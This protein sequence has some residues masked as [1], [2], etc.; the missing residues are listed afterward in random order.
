MQQL[1]GADTETH[2][3]TLGRAQETLMKGQ[4]RTVGARRVKATTRKKFTQSKTTDH[5]ES[6]LGRRKD[7]FS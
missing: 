6:Q 3:Q 4:R 7:K 1:M 5:R 2:I